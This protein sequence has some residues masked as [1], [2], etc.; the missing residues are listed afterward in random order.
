M[1]NE[2]N[3]K[4]DWKKEK[5]Y[6]QGFGFIISYSLGDFTIYN[7]GGGNWMIEYKNKDFEGVNGCL[8]TLKLSKLVCEGYVKSGY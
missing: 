8:P 7:V 2:T 6:D 3:N 5:T 1:N 4:M